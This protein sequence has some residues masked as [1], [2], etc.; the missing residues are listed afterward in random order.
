MLGVLITDPSPVRPENL[1]AV[2]ALEVDLLLGQLFV[3][4]HASLY[5]I[6]HNFE[7]FL[8]DN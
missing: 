1:F 2:P 4:L 7:V 3:L 5:I 8:N 6:I